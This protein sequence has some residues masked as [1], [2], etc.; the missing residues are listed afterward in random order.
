MLS[1]ERFYAA[2]I[3]SRPPFPFDCTCSYVQPFGAFSGRQR[4]NFV[5][6]RKRPPEKWSYFTSH[7]SLGSRRS[8]SPLRSV[9]QRLGPPGAW[10]VKPEPPLYGL[11]MDLSFLRSGA[12]KLELKP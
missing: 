9:L 6:W 12:V 10:P 1:A 8:H 2:S 5:P 11:S 4:K 7:T 3:F